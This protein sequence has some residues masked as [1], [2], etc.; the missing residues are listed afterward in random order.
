MDLSAQSGD[1]RVT[2]SPKCKASSQDLDS[3]Q[4]V[5]RM[6]NNAY[7]LFVTDTTDSVCVKKNCPE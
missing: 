3:T 7:L 6:M 2:C 1:L 5:T 4:G